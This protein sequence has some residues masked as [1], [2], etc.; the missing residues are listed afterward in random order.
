VIAKISQEFNSAN[1]LLLFTLHFPHLYCEE[2]DPI[3]PFDFSSAPDQREGNPNPD[4]ESCPLPEETL[5]LLSQEINSLSQ[6]LASAS[7][8][9]SR[10]S[11]MA[12]LE[13]IHSAKYSL[14]AAVTSAEGTSTLPDKETLV[15]N[16][17]S[18]WGETA[19]HMGVK[20]APKPK[21]KCLPEEHRLMEQAISVPNRKRQHNSDPYAG[22]EQ[23]GKR[24]KPDALSTKANR[25]ARA[26]VPPSATAP[27][28]STSQHL[29]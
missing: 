7:K 15:P 16:Q 17:K 21:Q 19:T 2:S 24:A 8:N 29:T 14:T 1:I 11:Y 22:G 28:S 3:N 10:S 4:L 9:I 13:A 20:H 26:C 12:V 23:S 27:T 5:Q 25:H 18:G 6:N